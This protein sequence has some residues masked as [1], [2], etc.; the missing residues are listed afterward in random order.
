MIFSH[1]HIITGMMLCRVDERNYIARRS[2]LTA[3]NFN[4]KSFA[5]RFATVLR[6]STPF[7]CAIFLLFNRLIYATISFTFSSVKSCLWPVRFL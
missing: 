7:L 6:A 5:F 2:K 4:A 1:T 3:V